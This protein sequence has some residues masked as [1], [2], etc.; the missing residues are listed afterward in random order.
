MGNKKWTDAPVVFVH[1][2]DSMS[3]VLTAVEQSRLA[4]LIDVSLDAKLLVSASH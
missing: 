1:D 4:E 3:E 2:C